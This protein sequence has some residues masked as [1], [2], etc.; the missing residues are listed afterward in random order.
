MGDIPRVSRMSFGEYGDGGDTALWRGPPSD[1]LDEAWEHLISDRPILPVT[2]ADILAMNKDPSVAVKMPETYWTEDGEETY[3]AKPA[4]LHGPQPA[5][6]RLRPPHRLQGPLLAQ[7]HRR[8]AMDTVQT[9]EEY[10]L[11]RGLNGGMGAFWQLV[12]FGM[13]IDITKEEEAA[14]APIYESTTRALLLS[15]EY[16][17]WEGEWYDAKL[18]KDSRNLWN[19]I[20][21]FMRTKNL[22]V[23]EERKLLVE[24]I[25]EEEA[26][27]TRE[28]QAYYAAHPSCRLDLRR[29]IE[30]I[31]PITAGNSL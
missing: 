4:A 7:R 26:R 1:E 12:Q 28:C 19:A 17:S 18:K 30:V 14:I 8:R 2:K 20:Y 25:H 3:M 10:Y 6:P 31:G 15:N 21:L 16:C 27:Y 24:I 11:Q 5:L 23:E 29:Y 13:D 22:T 9:L